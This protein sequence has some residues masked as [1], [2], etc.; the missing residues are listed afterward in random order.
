M[1]G[2]DLANLSGAL[3]NLLE[4]EVLDLSP[5][6]EAFLDWTTSHTLMTLI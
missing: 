1:R 4:L 2:K 6:R 5:E 3:F